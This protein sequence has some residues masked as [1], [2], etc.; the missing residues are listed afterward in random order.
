MPAYFD[1]FVRKAGTTPG[2][3]LMSQ[4]LPIGKAI[5]ELMLVWY[6]SE[7]EEWRNRLIWLPL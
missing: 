2:V 6:C 7:G 3:F 4:S 1:Q 5:E